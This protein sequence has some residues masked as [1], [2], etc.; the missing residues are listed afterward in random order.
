LRQC[1]RLGAWNVS[2]SRFVAMVFKI[3]IR[4]YNGLL[5]AVCQQHDFVNN[6]YPFL[7]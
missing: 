6:L 7:V 2:T 5:T 4:N 1:S 3:F